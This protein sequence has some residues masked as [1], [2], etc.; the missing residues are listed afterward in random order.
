MS[1]CIQTHLNLVIRDSCPNSALPQSTPPLRLS[2]PPLPPHPLSTQSYNNAT[3]PTHPT[4]P[5]PHLKTLVDLLPKHLLHP[6]LENSFNLF[7]TPLLIILTIQALRC[8]SPLKAL[9]RPASH[10]HP[11]HTHQACPHHLQL[12]SHRTASSWRSWHL[13]KVHSRSIRLT[14]NPST[15]RLL[16]SGNSLRW[17]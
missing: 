14:R 17:A 11:T 12:H 6:P 9:V 13:V 4:L 16:S 2:P 7:L 10:S 5:S 1:L 8:T 15:P 3:P